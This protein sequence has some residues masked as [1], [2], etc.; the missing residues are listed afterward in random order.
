MAMNYA[1]KTKSN[2][3]DILNDRDK[4][5]LDLMSII[6]NYQSDYDKLKQQLKVLIYLLLLVFTVGVLF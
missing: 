4:E 2:L 1:S 6:N 3:I 5:A